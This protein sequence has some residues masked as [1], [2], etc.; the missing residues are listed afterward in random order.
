MQKIPSI[1]ILRSPVVRQMSSSDR[2]NDDISNFRFNDNFSSAHI[3]GQ[4]RRV[5]TARVKSTLGV[6]AG[7]FPCFL[8]IIQEGAANVRLPDGLVCRQGAED[9]VEIYDQVVRIKFHPSIT[10]TNL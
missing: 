3:R 4:G 6:V 8:Q 5:H 9:G 2:F 1:G 7:Q 10:F